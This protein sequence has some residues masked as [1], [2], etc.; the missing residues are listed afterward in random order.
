MSDSQRIRAAATWVLLVL[1]AFFSADFVV[2]V[3]ERKLHPESGRIPTFQPT[4][5]QASPLPVDELN[6][7]LST[8]EDQSV[9]FEDKDEPETLEQ[10]IFSK[11]SLVGTLAGNNGQGLAFLEIEANTVALTPGEFVPDSS[12]L[13]VEVTS[14][15][16]VIRRRG[17]DSSISLGETC[18][19]KKSSASTGVERRAPTSISQ[20]EVRALLD[21]PDLLFQPGFKAT[22]KISDGRMI[23]AVVKLPNKEHPLARLG[24]ES[25]DLIKAI[26]QKP[27]DEAGSLS[28]LLPVLRNSS[29]LVIDI[30]RQGQPT[31]LTV[32]LD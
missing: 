18:S 13:I 14:G 27:L 11:F 15:Y 22:P 10:E 6:A 4:P 20:S 7:L 17:K 28:R 12:I 24:L 1:T 19:P 2:A 31:T 26:N 23:G 8:T 30:E 9:S 5:V 16:I 29:T 25:G 21:R 3:A 32:V